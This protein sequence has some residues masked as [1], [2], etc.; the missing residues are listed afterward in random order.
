VAKV[1]EEIDERLAAWVAEQKLFFVGTAPLGGEGHVNLSPKGRADV[2][3][4]VLGPNRVA[5]LDLTGSGAETIAHLRENGRICVML[6]AFEGPPRIVRF[7]GRGEAILLDDE[8]FAAAIEPFE[9]LG[10]EAQTGVRAVIQVEVDRI[11][12]SCGFVVP[13]YEYAGERDQMPRWLENKGR[14]GVLAYHAEKNV[15]SVDG[16]PAVQ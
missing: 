5:Y 7:H 9:P 16:L 8:R 15:T 4:R 1:F 10:V 13:L 11:G 14:E 6:C 2:F 3:F 12:D